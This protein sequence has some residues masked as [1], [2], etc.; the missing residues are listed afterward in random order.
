MIDRRLRRLLDSYG[1]NPRR[2]PARWRDRAEALGFGAA[3]AG[4][5]VAHAAALDQLLAAGAPVIGADRVEAMVRT[6]MAGSV[7]APASTPT[8]VGGW[9]PALWTPTSA[10]YLGL[11]VLGGVL[12]LLSQVP[13]A[14]TPLDLL[15]SGNLLPPLG[16]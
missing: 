4:A 11:L 15:F 7:R 5:E 16:G 14:E 10:V 9:L 1:A 2:W 13:P 12:N 8:P 6:V 3:E